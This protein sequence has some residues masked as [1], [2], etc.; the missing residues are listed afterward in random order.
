MRSPTSTATAS[1][2]LVAGKCIWAHE[3]GDPGADEPPAVYYYRWERDARGA[4]HATRSRLP[5]RVSA[6]GRQFA[7]ADV[8][9]DG[10]VDMVAP[11]ELGLNLFLNRG[12]E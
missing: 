12:Y 7:V 2:E 8:D 5:A 9:G 4:S 11:S 10:R 1:E 6:L 3:G